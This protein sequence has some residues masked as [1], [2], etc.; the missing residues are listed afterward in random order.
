MEENQDTISWQRYQHLSS[1]E[2]IIT[3]KLKPG[4]YQIKGSEFTISLYQLGKHY[5]YI[6]GTHHLIRHVYA[7]NHNGFK[8]RVTKKTTGE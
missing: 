6:D 4:R 2:M 1:G 3:R 5:K 8:V 7:I